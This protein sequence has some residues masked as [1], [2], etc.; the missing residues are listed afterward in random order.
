MP[1]LTCCGAGGNDLK[2]IG[3]RGASANRGIGGWTPTF[4]GPTSGLCPISLGV[5]AMKIDQFVSLVCETALKKTG[6]S[7]EA[8]LDFSPH[9]YFDSGAGLVDQVDHASEAVVCFAEGNGLRRTDR[10]AMYS[11]EYAGPR[12]R[13]ELLSELSA[14]IH[15]VFRDRDE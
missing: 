6:M 14:Y 4:G 5:Y 9:D 10:A 7:V 1:L 11:W 13:T 8:D 3:L 12:D 15:Q 2:V